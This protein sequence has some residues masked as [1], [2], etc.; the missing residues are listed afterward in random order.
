MANEEFWKD[1]LL[2]EQGADDV[3]PCSE[4]ALPAD[5]RAKIDNFLSG[6]LSPDERDELFETLRN[7]PDG[8]QRL[9]SLIQ[10][11]GDASHDA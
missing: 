5:L 6:K 9:A 7:R 1:L 11:P 2:F 10:R 8:I 4:E 3:I